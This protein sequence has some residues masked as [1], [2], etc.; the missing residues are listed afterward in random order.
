MSLH[1]DLIKSYVVN[2]T[3]RAEWPGIL[4]QRRLKAW[5][6]GNGEV[7]RGH[8]GDGQEVAT[9]NLTCGGEKAK[10]PYQPTQHIYYNDFEHQR[11]IKASSTP[12][13]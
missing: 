12:S 1:P 2:H 7:I 5:K 11:K 9:Y 4:A 3:S 10:E 8:R 6:P 13:T